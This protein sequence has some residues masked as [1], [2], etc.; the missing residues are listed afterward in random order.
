MKRFLVILATTVCLQ[1]AAQQR[2]TNPILHQDW[3]DPDVCRVGD[4][5]YMTASSFNFIPGLPILHSRD[6]V[7]WEIIGAALESYPSPMLTVEHGKGVWAPSIRYHDGWFYIYVGDPDRGIFMVR[8]QDP[9][10]PWEAPVWLWHGKGFIDPCPLW[11][12]DG[13]A[14]LSHAL[15]GSRAGLKSVVLVAPM[16]P[17]GTRLLGLSRIVFDGHA[18]QPTIEGTKFYKRDGWYYLF[19]PAGGVSTGWQTVL[20][21]S[22]PLGPWEEKIVMAWAPGTINGPH[23][24]AWVDTPAGSHWFLHFQDKGAYGRIVHLQPMSWAEDGWPMIGEDPD[25]DGIGQPVRSWESPFD[26]AQGDGVPSPAQGQICAGLP[27]AVWQFPSSG[28]RLQGG[29]SLWAMPLEGDGMRLFSAQQHEGYRTLW[30]CQNLIQQKFP[31]ES[32]NVGAVITFCPR[33]GLGEDCGFVVMGNSYAGFRMT[34]TPQ[35]ARLERISCEKAASDSTETVQFL[36]LLDWETVSV[37]YPAASGNVPQA[38]YPRARRASVHVRLEVRPKA[39]EGNVPD[40]MCQLLWSTDGKRFVKAGKPFRA[41]PD[42]WTGARFGFW[43][44]RSGES[45]DSGWADVRALSI[46]F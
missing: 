11:D 31:A 9:A 16:S 41:T 12:D 17:D 4:D 35:G 20:R 26:T 23:Q 10:G 39:V 43:C 13:K 1:A 38:K 7:N 24:G 28:Y 30:H 3:S 19:C 29:S 46:D 15:A 32:F 37:N 21:S 25:G 5:Y 42:M 6:L 36:R 22:S 27:S 33:E 34:D 14:Y 40:A 45:N 18:T 44:R 8:T 2:Y